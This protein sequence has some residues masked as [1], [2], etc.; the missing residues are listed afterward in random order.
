MIN[1]LYLCN[2][3]EEKK[4]HCKCIGLKCGNCNHTVDPQYAKNS[5]I[6]RSAQSIIQLFDSPAGIDVTLIEKEETG[7]EWG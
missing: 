7:Y 6:V 1:F 5:N 3:T 2:Q 4:K